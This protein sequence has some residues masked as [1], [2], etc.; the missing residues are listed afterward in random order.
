[1]V[2]FL[3][4]KEQDIRKIE[5]LG[6]VELPPKT[7]HE[8][9]RLQGSCTAVLYKSGKLLLQG[10]QE[11]IKKLRDYLIVH[12]YS[13]FIDTTLKENHVDVSGKI[14]GTDETLKGD[15]FGGLVVAGFLSD[16]RSRKKLETMGVVDSKRL[17]DRVIVIMANNLMKRFPN[18]FYAKS[19]LPREY[20]SFLA[21]SSITTLLNFLHEECYRKL[22]AEGAIHIVDKFPGATVGQIIET[23]AESKYI[24]VAAASIIARYH[25][26]EQMRKLELNAGFQI[27]MGSNDTRAALLKLKKDPHLDPADFVKLNFSNVREIFS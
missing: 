27:P 9:K 25:G 14:I 10:K 21:K 17:D 24:E 8:I 2:V 22:Y 3:N 16:D 7:E 5:N 11:D 26:L 4:F 13:D 6:F 12:G 20:N 19:V 15:T 1:M 18:S 23:K